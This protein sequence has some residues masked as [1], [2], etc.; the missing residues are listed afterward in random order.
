MADALEHRAGFVVLGGRSN[1][2]KS[3]LLNRVVGQKVAI[4]TPRPQTTRRRIVGIRTDPDAQLVLIDTPGIHESSKELNR[5][6]VEVARHA[7]TEGEVL[8]GVIAAGESIY[9]ADRAVLQQLDMLKARLIIVINKLDLVPRPH[10][11]PLI[12]ELHGDFPNAEIVPV[13]ALRGDNV[14][15]LVATVK[16]MLPVGPALMPEDQYTDQSERMIAEELVREKIFLAMREEIPFSTAVRVEKFVDQPERRLKSISV[17]VIVERDSHKAMLI[18]ARGRTLKQIGTAARLELENLFETR[19][20]LT[21]VVKVEP[22]WTRDPRR[23]AEY[24]T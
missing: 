22:G 5:R 11:L 9:P 18:G 23:V 20:F 2:G 14:E 3:T 17:L 21:M 7:L 16:Q 1:V 12:E 24:G 13:S 15:E 19:V 4:V 6:M 8:L 10:L